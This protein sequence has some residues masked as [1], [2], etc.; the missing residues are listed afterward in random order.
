MNSTKDRAFRPLGCISPAQEFKGRRE[1]VWHISA[2][3]RSNTTLA[4]MRFSEKCRIT[5]WYDA[6]AGRIAAHHAIDVV[7]SNSA[8]NQVIPPV[9][10]P[11]YAME[12]GT[13]VAAVSSN[14]PV[15]YPS[16]MSW[17]P[18]PQP[19]YVKIRGSDGYYTLYMHITPIVSNGQVVT[20]GQ[21]IGTID[22]S[23]CQ[24]NHHVHVSRKDSSGTIYNFVI[25]GCVNSPTPVNWYDDPEVP[26]YDN[27]DDEDA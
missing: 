26:I 8:G 20:Q 12:A 17:S 1:G 16:C 13:V 21:E 10:T 25:P 2:T 24:S 18:R 27:D 6:T 7:Q 3:I 14:G 5:S 4:Q 15:S 23:G 19:N 11:I 22:G 9:G